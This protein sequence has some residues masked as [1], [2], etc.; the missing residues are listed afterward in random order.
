MVP[1]QPAAVPPEAHPVDKD[2]GDNVTATAMIP[3]LGY[4]PAY[5]ALCRMAVN[6]AVAPGWST[7]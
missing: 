4:H 7:P 2:N 1:L 3:G 6:H 5:A